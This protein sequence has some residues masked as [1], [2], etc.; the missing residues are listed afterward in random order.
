MR[1]SNQEFNDPADRSMNDATFAQAIILVT[2]KDW[3]EAIRTAIVDRKECIL[4]IRK[5]HR[6]PQDATIT[7]HS[8][9]IAASAQNADRAM[10]LQTVSL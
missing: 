1:D 5:S 10:P 4:K 6:G 7:R 3:M 9:R 2:R 8:G